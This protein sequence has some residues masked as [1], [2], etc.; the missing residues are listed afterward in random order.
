[1]ERKNKVSKDS[2]DN[3]A[4]GSMQRKNGALQYRMTGRHMIA[5]PLHLMINSR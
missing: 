5:R 3:M 4:H 1:M 2:K